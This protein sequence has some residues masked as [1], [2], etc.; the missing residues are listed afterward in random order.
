MT[1]TRSSAASATT[2]SSAAP[3]M[4]NCSATR[5]TNGSRAAEGDDQLIGD[6][7]NPFGPPLDD[8]DTAV[9]VGRAKNHTITANADGR[10]LSATTSATAAPTR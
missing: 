2:S 6:N 8:I 10:S 9:F 1:R 5:A 7:G 4:M 3:A